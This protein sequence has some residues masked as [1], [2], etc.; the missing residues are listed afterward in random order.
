MT[1]MQK[2]ITDSAS[3]VGVYFFQYFT[4]ATWNVCSMHYAGHE[5]SVC[6]MVNQT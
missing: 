1:N 4:H 2:H 5:L 6:Q 3:L